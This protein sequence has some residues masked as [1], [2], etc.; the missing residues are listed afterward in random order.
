MKASNIKIL[1]SCHKESDFISNSILMPIQ[2]GTALSDKR[3]PGIQ[4]DDEGENISEQNMKYCE[5]TAQYWAWK[6]LN[7]DYYGFF[8]YRRYLSFNKLKKNYDSYG[9]IYRKYINDEIVS[10]LSLDEESILKTVDGADVIL[11]ERKD[12]RK[13]PIRMGRNMRDQYEADGQLRLEDLDIMIQVLHEKYPVYDT[14]VEKYFRGCY[15]YLNNMFVMKKELFFDYC[16]WLFGILEECDKRLD[17]TEFSIERYRTLGHFAERLL[18]IYLIPLVQDKTIRVKELQTVLFEDT[19]PKRDFKPAFANNNVAVALSANEKYVPYVS[20]LLQ[21]IKN[22]V[23]TDK[24]YDF[25]IMT[26]DIKPHSQEHLKMVFKD[27]DNVSVR[28]INVSR[29]EDFFKNVFLHGHFVI[30]TWFRL[31]M[32]ELLRNYDKV[33]YLDS[34]MVVN[35]D[36]AELY[37]TDIDDYLLAACLDPDTAGLYNGFQPSKRVYMDNVLKMEEPYKYFQAG[38]ILFNLKMFRENYST[39]QILEFASS[40]KWELL[41]QDVL[42]CLAQGKVKYVDMSWNV[43][44]DWQYIRE[45]EIIRRAPK[46]MYD[47]YQEARKNPRIIHYAGPEKPWDDPDCDF[48]DHFWFYAKD[49]IYCGYI[50]R[51]LAV[52]ILKNKNKKKKIENMQETLADSFDWILPRYTLRREKAKAAWR[53]AVQCIR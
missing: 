33:L 14:A 22:H 19:T 53:F 25:I 36:I 26:K 23:S 6:N 48:A 46:Y 1:I 2:V 50:L 43:M 41:D 12:L 40:Q 8:H 10:E 28:F 45:K 31:L 20:V 21:S 49:S 38:T 11:P 32:P 42:N 13:M 15:S 18:N 52:N 34:D 47:M 51:Q 35:A 9:N 16:E 24:N 5:L 30:E 39:K 29:Y 7:A 4:H 3:L 44:Y 27:Y 17:Y 37:E